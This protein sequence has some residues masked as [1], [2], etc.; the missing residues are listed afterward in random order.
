MPGCD[1]CWGD[2]HLRS[3]LT[4]RDQVDCF[5]EILE[6]RKDNPCSIEDQYRDSG[7]PPKEIGIDAAEGD[8]D[9]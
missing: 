4:G 6:E 1:K 9:G 8:G 5:Y 2:A 7:G 3:A